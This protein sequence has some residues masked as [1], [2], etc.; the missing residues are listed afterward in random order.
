MHPDGSQDIYG[1]TRGLYVD[2]GDSTVGWGY[3]LLSHQIDAFGNTNRFYY[4]TFTN[5]TT[6][7][8]SRLQYMVDYDGHTNYLRYTTNN[9]LS[10]VENPYGQKAVF[11]YNSLSEVTN[12]SDALGLNSGVLYDTNGW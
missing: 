3:A 2:P 11:K 6:T 7:T 12:I 10:E 1:E 8:A 4:P 5:G 9:L